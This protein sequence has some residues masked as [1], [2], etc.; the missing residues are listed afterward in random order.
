MNLGVVASLIPNLTPCSLL[1]PQALL[2]P[3]LQLKLDCFTIE[4][5]E[6]S[7]MESSI[8]QREREDMKLVVGAD[9]GNAS[10]DGP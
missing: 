3:C 2:D 4:G 8:Y 7:E 10:Q 5:I 9:M 1:L 6:W